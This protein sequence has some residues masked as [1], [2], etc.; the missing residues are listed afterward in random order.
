MVDPGALL[1]GT[2]QLGAT[3]SDAGSGVDTL[4]F[5]YSPA[6][7]NDWSPTPAGWNTALVADGSYDL[8][9]VVTDHAGN[10]PR[11]SRSRPDG[12]QH[13]ADA[14]GHRSGRRRLHQRRP[15]R[16]R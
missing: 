13:V 5:Q 6:G 16:I 2:V 10:S 7:Q 11:P 15:P 3:T 12:R 8:R 9:V 1:T 14:D 4:T